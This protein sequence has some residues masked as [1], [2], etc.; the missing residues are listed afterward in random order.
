MKV[1]STAASTYQLEVDGNTCWQVG[2]NNVP[3]NTWTW[4]DWYSGNSTQKVNYTFTTGN[5]TLKLIGSSVNVQVDKVIL[6]GSGELCS[7]KGTVPTGDG[8]NCAS[9]PAVTP[10]GGGSTTPTPP[11]VAGT[12]TPAIVASN[13]AN[14]TQTSYLVNGKVV[15]T[16]D[17]AA[18]LDTTKLANGTYDVQTVVKL[19]DGSEVTDNQTITIK[20][21]TS[22]FKKYRPAIIAMVAVIMLFGIAYAAWRLFYRGDVSGIAEKFKNIG[23]KNQQSTLPEQYT[24][25]QVV[26]PSEKLPE[27]KNQGIKL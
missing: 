17:G 14:A 10:T 19:K 4:V 9:A 8:T 23:G 20:N 12:T 18:A 16:S 15:Q 13:Q 26:K 5:H 24:E 1:P 7:D 21:N 27:D 11:V 3:V 22:I 25:P 2:G 6:L